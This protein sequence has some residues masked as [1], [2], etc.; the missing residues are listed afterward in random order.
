MENQLITSRR[1]PLIVETAAL[2]EKKYRDRSGL[3]LAEGTV[4]LSEALL[5]GVIPQKVFATPARMPRAKDLLQERCPLIPVSEEVYEKLS[6]EDAP[7]GVLAVFAIPPHDDAPPPQGP[8]LLLENL[9]DPGNVGTVIR[10]AAALGIRRVV[11]CGCAD[12]YNPKTVRA[13]MGALFR[14][15]PQRF[16]RVEDAARTLLSEGKTLF[17]AALDEDSVPLREGILS[18]DCA[19]LIGNEGHGLSPEAKALCH[20]KLI[21][22][23]D[24]MESLNAAVAAAVFLWEMKKI[25]SKEDGHV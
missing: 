25:I 21:I 3:F 11:M 23:M 20:K 6:S 22:P 12:L 5:S 17:A 9:Q 14:L 2:K 16:V 1:N 18:P 4:L 8:A 13:T 10:T 15:H 7:E 24:G 19:V